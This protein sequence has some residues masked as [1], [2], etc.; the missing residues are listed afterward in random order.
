MPYSVIEE[1]KEIE[2]TFLYKL[3]EHVKNQNKFISILDYQ[4]NQ[5]W[6]QNEF[7]ELKAACL[8]NNEIIYKTNRKFDEMILGD[9]DSAVSN[10]NFTK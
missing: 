2:S 1:I 9:S 7:E 3:G 6:L 4:A 8:I 5:E 10:V